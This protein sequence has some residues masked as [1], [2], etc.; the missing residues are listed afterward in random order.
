MRGYG[1]KDP[2]KRL[3]DGESVLLIDDTVIC[4]CT[5]RECARVLKENGA[6]RVYGL[7]VGRGID[8]KRLEFLERVDAHHV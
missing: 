6:G 8:R 5:M 7:V 3:I 1:G 4:G 2:T